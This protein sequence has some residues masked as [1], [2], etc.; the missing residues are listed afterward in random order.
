MINPETLKRIKKAGVAEKKSKIVE[1]C[2][3]KSVLDVGCVGQDIDYFNPFWIHN[4]IKEVCT[5][6]DGVDIDVE[7]IRLLNEKGYSVCL[8]EDLQSLNKKYDIVLM[9][10]VIEHVNDPVAFLSFYSKFLNESGKM[11]IA[12]PNAHGIRNFTS[13]LLRNDYSLNHEHT[14]WLCPKTISEIADRADLKFADFF[15]LKEYFKMKDLKGIMNKIVYMINSLL[16]KTRTNFNP[17]FMFI[18]SK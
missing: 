14:F 4:L 2:T 8:A 15:W 12:T 6:I 5:V 7:G 3:A 13:I 16:Q 10:D 17:N 18:A 11:V 1:L 9:S